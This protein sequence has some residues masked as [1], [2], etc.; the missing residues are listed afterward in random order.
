MKR[1]FCIALAF[2]L[3]VGCTQ[4]VYLF[5]PSEQPGHASWIRDA[6]FSPDGKKIV[7]AGVDGVALIWEIDSTTPIWE[8]EPGKELKRLVHTHSLFRRF[9]AG[10]K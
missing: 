5:R 6:A 3:L 2:L 8:T 7:T 1:S 4:K 10:R 9:F